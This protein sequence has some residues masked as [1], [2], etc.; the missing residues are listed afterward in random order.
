[1][2]AN[3]RSVTSNQQPIAGVRALAS[4]A[5][6]VGPGL[7]GRLSRFASSGQM[8]PDSERELGRH[9]GARI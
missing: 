9:S 7:A 8:G 1:M 3:T 6:R 2:T 5:R 4:T